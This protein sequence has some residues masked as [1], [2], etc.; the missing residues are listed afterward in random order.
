MLR[1]FLDFSLFR[2]AMQDRHDAPAL[3]PR[4]LRD[5]SPETRRVHETH[6][7]KTLTAEICDWD[8]L[9]ALST[10]WADLYTRCLEPNIFLHPDFAIPA[11]AYL[12]PKGLRI[13]A[14]FDGEGRSRRL[15]A[16]A[17]IIMPRLPFGVAR[18]FLHK[19]TALGLPLVDQ[20]L[21]AKV[22]ATLLEAIK[23]HPFAPSALVFCEIPRDGATFRLL[24]DLLGGRLR[25]LADYERAALFLATAPGR[26]NRKTKSRKNALRLLRRF[27]ERGALSYRIWRDADVPAAMTEFLA[28]EAS[29]W[30]GTSRTALASAPGRTAFASEVAARFA[31]AQKLWLESLDLDGK[32]VAMGIMLEDHAGLYFWK[33]AY[34]EAFAPYSPGALFIRELTNRLGA[35]RSVLKVDSCARP[36]HPMIDRL[37]PDRLAVADIGILLA[38]RAR[39]MLAL[40]VERV[41]RRGRAVLKTLLLRNSSGKAPIAE[42]WRAH[43]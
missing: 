38:P 15:V 30:K 37:W 2:R 9:A 28:L 39:G 27:S 16:V 14:V 29:G 34:N 6:P 43:S 33:T 17:P 8:Q 35:S 3:T 42:T 26:I 7:P 12:R 20:Q 36:D 19:Q 40:Q 32:P 41:R 21:A 23:A 22:L 18:G 31:P 11:L 24:C 1:S 10:A 25:V 13:V 4:V 5:R